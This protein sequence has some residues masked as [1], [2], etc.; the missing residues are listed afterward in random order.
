MRISRLILMWNNKK[1][2]EE[3]VTLIEAGKR[4]GG[5]QKS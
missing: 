1:G 2:E 4:E 3:A 5:N